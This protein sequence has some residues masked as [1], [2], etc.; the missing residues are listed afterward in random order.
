VFALVAVLDNDDEN[1]YDAKVDT[2]ESDDE[3]N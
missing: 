2:D 1:E 3:E